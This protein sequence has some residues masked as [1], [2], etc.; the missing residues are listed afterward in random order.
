MAPIIS[1]PL[2]SSSSSLATT[3]TSSITRQLSSSSV[4]SLAI[5]AA[6]SSRTNS[7]EVVREEGLR[8][9]KIKLDARHYKNS[10]FTLQFLEV[11]KKLHVPSWSRA[12]IPPE[13]VIIHKVSGALTNAVFFVSCPA[14]P[15]TRT[16]LLRIYGSSSGSLISRPRELHILHILSSIY[17]IGPRVY[18]TFENGRIEEYFDSV[19]LTHSDIR[20]PQISRWI[21]ARMAEL[22]SVDISVVDGPSSQYLTE[23]NGFQI[24]ANVKSWLLPAEEVLKLHCVP[25]EI[26]KELDLPKFRDEWKGYLTWVLTQGSGFGSKRVFAHNDAQYGNLLRL[27]DGSE[28]VDEHRQIIVVDFEYAAPNPAAYDIANHFQEWTA[29]YHCPTPHLLSPPCYPT[30][31]ERRNFYIS[32]IHHS[33]MLAEDPVLDESALDDLIQ[34]LDRDV[35]LW[36]AASHAGWAIWGIVQAREDL[37]G[38]VTEPEFDYIGYAR[39][40]MSAFRKAIKDTAIDL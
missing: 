25:D 11:V 38:N 2:S 13:D 4:Q 12:E 14:I 37:E 23:G 21:G 18:G 10:P 15:S 36:T 3:S 32:Y 8:H 30:F 19:T 20:D 7:V 35:L 24:A 6:S 16:L 26:R 31:E 34:N 27:R 40:R 33:A 28:G 17:K 9:A 39:G 1:P 5:F 29:N 22:H